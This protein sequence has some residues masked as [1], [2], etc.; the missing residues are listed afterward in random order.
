MKHYINYIVILVVGLFLGWFFFGGSA[1]DEGNH[2]HTEEKSTSQMWTCSMHLQIMQQESGDCPICGMDLI[3]VE[4]GGMGLAADQFK[5]TK[6]AMA[7]AN[8]QT[9]IVGVSTLEDDLIKLSGKIVENEDN[10]AVQTAHFSGRIE[11]LYIKSV[12]EKIS[13]GQLLALIYSPELVSAQ[14]E[15]LTALSV[16]ESQPKLYKAI[17]NK[18]KLWKLSDKQINK[19]ET[20]KEPITNF[21]VYANVSGI[22]SLKMV[23]E[24]NHVMEGAPLFKISNLSTVW[25]NFD[26]YEN[27]IPF[28]KV[29]QEVLITT[30]AYSNKKFKAKVSFINPILNT[31][32]RTVELRAVLNNKASLFKPGMFVEGKIRGL[33]STTA[34]TLI[35]PASAILWTGERSVV[36]VKSDSEEPIFEMREVLLGNSKGDTYEVLEGLNNGDEIV[37]NGTFTID[38][39][40]QLQGVKS[41]MNKGGGKTSTGHQGHTGMQNLTSNS[42]GKHDSINTR[43]QVSSTFQAQL[44]SVFDSYISL[45]DALVKDDMHA[46]KNQTTVILSNLNKVDVKLLSNDDSHKK[47]MSFESEINSALVSIGKATTINDQRDYFMKLSSN[48][49][50]AVEVFGINQK[51]YSQFCP[52]ANGNKGAYWL[53]SEAK[54]LNPYFGDAMLTCG[55][56]KKII[57]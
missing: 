21:P 49:T 9:S 25:A 5:L 20:S 57:E 12:G 38:A 34:E 3:P 18:L 15:L 31:K 51:V 32:T 54:I 24:G 36:Y 27:Q 55:S 52:M 29:G 33:K 47:W 46:V 6:N 7:L 11:K 42:D 41:M 10:V 35:V 45:K 23:E 2:V 30:K 1:T 22:V 17:R 44:K 43:I 26:V 19:I 50:S 28:F 40:A 16:K 8:I 48:L 37:T 39:A 4:T 13:R 14:S 56:V 53:S